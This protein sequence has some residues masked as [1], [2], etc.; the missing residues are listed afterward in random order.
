MTDLELSY[1][2]TTSKELDIGFSFRRTFTRIWTIVGLLS[3]AAIASSL[4]GGEKPQL[5]DNERAFAD[6]IK[7]V[8]GWDDQGFVSRINEIKPDFITSLEA[9]S[10]PEKVSWD[11]QRPFWKEIIRR[12][13]ETYEK[14]QRQANNQQKAIAINYRKEIQDLFA[15]RLELRGGGSVSWEMGMYI[16]GYVEW[17]L[18]HINTEAERTP[19][20]QELLQASL[21]SF[22]LE[23]NPGAEKA[24][25]GVI[26]D[27]KR[28]EGK[29]P[30]KQAAFL[31]AEFH[32]FFSKEIPSA[33]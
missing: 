7:K 5:L 32:R 27:L 16:P 33:N 31:R 17:I 24:V 25:K 22:P 18:G 10:D 28:I 14:I 30:K 12:Y 29:L 3:M 6:R 26:S 9:E 8:C 4:Q 15:K 23:M 11:H 1:T 19:T 2:R 20:D 13:A 21:A